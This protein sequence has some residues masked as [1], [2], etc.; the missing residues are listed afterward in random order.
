MTEPIY[1]LNSGGGQ[2]I[3]LDANGDS[4]DVFSV[5]STGEPA[6]PP[7]VV[8]FVPDPGIL[9]WGSDLLTWGSQTLSWGLIASDA[10]H[11][12]GPSS[13]DDSHNFAKPRREHH[14][15]RVAYRLDGR[16]RFGT[17]GEAA[18][19]IQKQ[20]RQDAVRLR[21]EKSKRAAKAAARIAAQ[22]LK[23]RL[24]I[25]E[26]FEFPGVGLDVVADRMYRDL[27]DVYSNELTQSLQ[28]SYFFKKQADEEAAMRAA[29]ILLMR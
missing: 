12:P 28:K 15:H 3:L 10:P 13:G 18:E 23:N 6:P 19:A 4:I 17:Y 20:A 7:V 2:D 16:L 11:V 14:R 24:T 1:V 21:A 27:R 5:E 29:E 25:E 9:I 22:Q 8:P 26:A